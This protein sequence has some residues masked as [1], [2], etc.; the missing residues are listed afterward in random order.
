MPS[1]NR[2]LSY[3]NGLLLLLGVAFGI[4]FFDRNAASILVPFIEHDLHLDNTQ[5][6]F[7]GSGLSITWALGAYL[8]SRWSDAS[9]VRKPF[10]LSFLFIFSACSFLSGLARSY[11]VLLASRMLMGAVEGPFLPVCLAIMA[12]ESSPHRRGINAGIMQNFFASILGQ[13]LAPLLLVPLAAYLGW[14]S[15]FYIAGVPGLACAVAVWLWVREPSA[16]ER[17]ASAPAAAADGGAQR[18]FFAMLK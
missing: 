8:I 1:Q 11:P 4:A 16:A 14:R 5:V 3:E 7:I 12:A 10:L 17:A 13:S 9:G 2:L 6:G 18:G 15:A